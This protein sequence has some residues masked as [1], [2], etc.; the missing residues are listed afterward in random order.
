[1]AAIHL[2]AQEAHPDFGQRK[3][4]VEGLEVVMKI[5]GSQGR[6]RIEWVKTEHPFTAISPASDVHANHN[7]AQNAAIRRRASAYRRCQNLYAKREEGLQRALDVQRLLHNWVRPH[8]SLGKSVTPAIAIAQLFQ[9][10]PLLQAKA[11]EAGD[12]NDE[13][14]VSPPDELGSVYVGRLTVIV[15]AIDAMTNEDR[16]VIFLKLSLVSVLNLGAQFFINY[17]NFDPYLYPYHDNANLEIAQMVDAEAL[18][19]SLFFW[20]PFSIIST[21]L[22]LG[23]SLWSYWKHRWPGEIVKSLWR[24]L[25]A[26]STTFLIISSFQMVDLLRLNASYKGGC[27]NMM[28]D[29]P[30]IQRL[31]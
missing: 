2:K 19:A 1:M 6:R 12:V 20:L 16:L 25:I 8:F 13:R 31:P 17:V 22:S 28:G 4:W 5:K 7:E 9:T 24:I 3:V 18:F 26:T 14:D 23:I 15:G 27:I 29:C 10:E 21:S 30:A 11:S